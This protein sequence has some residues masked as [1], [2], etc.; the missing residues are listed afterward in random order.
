MR[1]AHLTDGGLEE[2][3][4][5][6][7]MTNIEGIAEARLERNGNTSMIKS[8]REPKVITAVVANGVHTVRI[9]LA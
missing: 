6:H 4:R 2:D 5:R 8:K 7:G 9:V 3:L 1:I